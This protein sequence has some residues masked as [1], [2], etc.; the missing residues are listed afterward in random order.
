MRVGGETITSCS[1]CL[2]N[3]TMLSCDVQ[4]ADTQPLRCSAASFLLAARGASLGS[5]HCEEETAAGEFMGRRCC[6]VSHLGERVAPARGRLALLL[7]SLHL[8]GRDHLLA[9][10][11]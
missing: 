2:F 1:R 11:F 4:A 9:F 10:D 8:S 5:L 6:H 7:E 3:D